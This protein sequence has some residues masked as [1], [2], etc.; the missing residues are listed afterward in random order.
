PLPEI[1]LVA[2][3]QL[4]PQTEQWRQWLRPEVGT[5]WLELTGLKPLDPGYVAARLEI[6][7]GVPL[8]LN[9][10]VEGVQL[11]QI[12]PLID[13]I[14]TDISAG[15]RTGTSRL[16]VVVTQ[17]DS[18]QFQFSYDNSRSLATGSL[19][20]GAQFSQGNLLGWGDRLQLAYGRTQGSEDWDIFY[21]VPISPYNTTVSLNVG[22]TTSEIIDEIFSQLDL[23]SQ[24]QYTN[25][26]IRQ[27]IVQ[28][29]L[30]E[31]ALSL[32]LSHTVTR[33]TFLGGVPFPTDGADDEG[34]TRVTALRFGQEWLQRGEAQVIA[35]QSEFS[36][37]LDTLGATIN[38]EPPDSRFF[39]WQGRA[40]WARLLGPDFLLLVRGSLQLAD[41]PLPPTEQ[42]STAGVSTVRGYRQNT[43]VTDNGWSAS[44]E[45]Q[46]PVLRVPELEGLFQIA[47]FV[48]MGGGWYHPL[49]D[50]DPP[51]VSRL[52][53]LG[54]GFIWTQ[55]D[56]LR[57]RL[58]WGIPL[59]VVESD[60]NSL[61]ES[62][63]HF[64]I[65]LTPP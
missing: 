35:L 51:E 52:S 63:L 36:L 60:G 33:S 53:S 15:N 27:P 56:Y 25:L 26:G 50:N 47:P 65:I 46:I 1:P 64:S 37:G 41:R 24:A 5:R 18:D 23:V 21:E 17:A 39:S 13:R 59:T 6:A 45:L 61:Q 48:D 28:S 16:Q 10:L 3:S 11:L 55:G 38:D 7:G 57:A 34:F 40:Q 19:R 8:N 58:D 9:D 49:S 14:A 42:V 22:Q 31:L 2:G 20:Q 30:N 43:L 54:L 44:A 4:D 62:G 29:P 32:T 12:N